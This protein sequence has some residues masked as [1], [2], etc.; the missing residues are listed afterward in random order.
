MEYTWDSQ[1]KRSAMLSST[2]VSM[3][4]ASNRNL[5]RTGDPS[6]CTSYEHAEQ[7]V[8]V[9]IVTLD[10]AILSENKVSLYLPAQQPVPALA[11]DLSES[12]LLASVEICEIMHEMARYEAERI[13]ACRVVTFLS[14][15]AKKTLSNAFLANSDAAGDG[16][17]TSSYPIVIHTLKRM[18]ATGGLGEVIDC[19][20]ERW[21]QFFTF[22][23]AFFRQALTSL[24]FVCSDVKFFKRNV[25]DTTQAIDKDLEK[26]DHE[27]SFQTHCHFHLSRQLK[28]DRKDKREKLIESNHVR[29]YAKT[30]RDLHNRNKSSSF[31]KSSTSIHTSTPFLDRES[32]KSKL[33]KLNL[34]YKAQKERLREVTSPPLVNSQKALHRLDRLSNIPPCQPFPWL[35]HHLFELGG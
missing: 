20:I 23:D 16:L 14:K 25:K 22:M 35:W 9:P 28:K 21:A 15:A 3:V 10:A 34:E 5:Q 13:H 12:N 24:Q 6:F 31:S 19:H 26:M 18:A 32:V 7:A 2:L 33:S 11:P 17:R 8:H 4:C 1:T 30:R 27:F 29:D